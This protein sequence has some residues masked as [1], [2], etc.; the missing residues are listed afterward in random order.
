LKKGGIGVVDRDGETQW[1]KSER[2]LIPHPILIEG[3]DDLREIAADMQF[4]QS[5]EQI[6]RPIFAVAEKQ[7]TQKQITEF[8]GGK[9]QQLNFAMS[10]CRRLGY[11]V[12]GGSACCKVWENGTP[13]EARYWIGDEYPEGETYTGELIF[14]DE[15]QNPIKID[16]V[17]PVTFSE[18]MRMA[19]SIYA[20]RTVEKEE[21]EEE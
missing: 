1:L 20:K 18:G 12:R 8:S 11:L 13:L 10:L 17:G 9:F 3:L 6:F 4:S 15:D 7:K 14:V 19:S 5:V 2:I 16:E 21:G